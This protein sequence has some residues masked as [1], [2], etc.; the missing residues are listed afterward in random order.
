M[1]G[2][3]LLWSFSASGF[4]HAQIGDEIDDIQ[5]VS[6]S[7]GKVHLLGN[8]TANVF[9]FFKPGQEHSNSTLK[10]MALCEKEFAGKS[11]RWVAI[12]SDRFPQEAVESEIKETGI[13]MPVLIDSGDVLYGKLGV[14]LTPVIGLA[15]KDHKLVA[16]LPFAKVNYSE[17]IG[18]RI[19]RL[20]GEINDQELEQ[21]LKPPEMVQGSD[22]EL[23]RRRLKLAE[24]LFQ[25]GNYDKALASV[26][27]SIE[28]DS[29]SP[30]AHAL[31]GQ[32]LAA[33]G[34]KA[35]ALKAFNAALKLD[36]TNA[37]A[38]QGKKAATG[39]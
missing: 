36:P 31:L 12:V 6:L 7:G 33:Q 3:I 30:T 39:N 14:S 32:I 38:L 16:Y 34:N 25:G 29:S 35:E 13:T 10:Q 18:A 19:R 37:T 1:A 5:L 26:N 2:T 22:P 11:V 24:K 15:D 28:K 23:A 17:V 9:I 21:V 8:A 4:A 27:R 20:L